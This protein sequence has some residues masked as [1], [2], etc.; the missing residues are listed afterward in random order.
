MIHCE[1]CQYFSERY[2]VDDFGEI[3]DACSCDL[4]GLLDTTEKDECREFSSIN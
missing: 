1:H 4:W 2:D 3:I